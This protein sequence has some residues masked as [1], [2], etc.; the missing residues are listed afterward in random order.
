MSEKVDILLVDDRPENLLAL[1]AILEPL[2][3]HLVRATSG[4]EALR[5]VLTRDYACILLDVQMP[6]LNGFDTAR[7]I[8]ARERSRHIPIIFLTAISK[9][10]EYVFEGYQVGAVDYMSKPFQPDI[11]RSKVAVFVE[12]YRKQQQLKR[13]EEQLRE[14][15][16]MALELEHRA[17]LWQSEARFG[18]IV[19]SAMDAIIT[20]DDEHRITLFN[21]AAAR[22]FGIA[23]DDARAMRIEELFPASFRNTYLERICATATP[24]DGDGAPASPEVQSF[25]G[26]RRGSGEF[27][28]E[29]S[30]SCLE[31]PT[32]RLYTIIARDVSERKRAE[33]ALRAQALSLA[34]TTAK[35]KIA[36]EE[37]HQRQLDLERAMTA[38]SR[39]YASMSHEL[40]TPIN[41][42]LG[43]NTLL[44][45]NIYG[46]LNEKQ[47]DGLRR[48]QRA[49]KHLLELVNDVLDLSKIEAGKLE[50][51][52]Q[53]VQF[54]M[55]I[56]DLFVTVRPMAEERGSTLELEH[57][58]EH[59]TVTSDPRRVRQILLNLLSN[60]IKFGQGNPIRV[61]STTRPEGGICIEVID[62]GIGIASD[63]LPRVFDE[64]VQLSRSP[65]HE[66][67]GLGLPISR[68][69]ALLL[70][71]ELTADSRPGEGS[72]FRLV[73]PPEIDS[74]AAA[75]QSLPLVPARPLTE[76]QP[77]PVEVEP[78]MAGRGSG[79]P[80][81]RPRP[82]GES[83]ADHRPKR[84]GA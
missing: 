6:G 11:L 27:P 77:V 49:A 26:V 9:E 61:V 58:G 33:E 3:E 48:T 28:I 41:A 62:H 52:V 7:L 53:P 21:G 67:T 12:L 64:F 30:V 20:F 82:S 70:Q 76:Q 40:R 44:L 81:R 36:N 66:G 74:R 38:R 42:I 84:G 22:L 15:E 65:E 54:P 1:E 60:A 83:A 55:L 78:E 8:K 57:H 79:G 25:V 10:Q 18:E 45:E 51:K 43:Y 32:G 68:R 37:L 71:G 5:C 17:E 4:D 69:L 47:A 56:E 14:H 72:T 73:L 50:L 80:D 31:L 2:G 35:L 39:F 13:Q 24:R 23:P 34:N 59:V 19:N 63:D 29:A 75:E 46:A 16:R